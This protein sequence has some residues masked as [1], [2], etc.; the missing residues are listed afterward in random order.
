LIF[1]SVGTQSKP[2]NR[3]IE[4]VDSIAELINEPIIIQTGYSTYAPQK[5]EFFKFCSPSEMQKY[6]ESSTL[7]ISQAGFGIIGD[8]I[9]LNKPIILVPREFQYGEAVDKQYELAE[10]LDDQNKSIIC[11]RNVNRLANA[12]EQIRN[13]EVNYRYSTNIP[14]VISD[15]IT[16]SYKGK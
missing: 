11:V 5:C 7:V 14:E 16:R 2:F 4:G 1:V 13:V 8:C 10:Y 12:I 9:K 6:I 15:F 3:L